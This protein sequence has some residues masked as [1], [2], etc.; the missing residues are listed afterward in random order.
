MA[1]DIVVQLEVEHK[2]IEKW[3]YQ[4]FIRIQYIGNNGALTT[5]GSLL[6]ILGHC[7]LK[8]L[9]VVVRSKQ[10]LDSARQC[11]TF[12]TLKA[13]GKIADGGRA[14]QTSRIQ[15]TGSTFIGKRKAVA[16]S[17]YSASTTI[18]DKSP[19]TVFKQI[20]FQILQLV[21]Q[22]WPKA[23]GVTVA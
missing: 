22:S 4:S 14:Q 17:F 3:G 19:T 15:D 1:L 11:H 10:L 18:T 2:G 23:F 20:L 5:K 21:H 12:H 13:S 7:K 9:A 16:H 8:C 6:Y